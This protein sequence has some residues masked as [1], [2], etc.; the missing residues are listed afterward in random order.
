MTALAGFWRNKTPAPPP[1]DAAPA[2]M[3]VAHGITALGI[4]AI[5][6][7]L[8]LLNH[9][10]FILGPDT[11]RAVMKVTRNVYRQGFLQPLLIAL[12]LFQVGSGVCLATHS[13]VLPMD[14]FHTF[15]IASGIFLA[16]YVLG[17]TLCSCL[18]G[19]ISASKRLGLRHR[20]AV[21]VG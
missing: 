5:F 15:Q 7:A 20:R 4:I 17:H 16:A 12:F 9:L 8:H 6:L 2:P 19:S 3:R 11:Y 10:T 13:D 18:R 14:R 1:A 21:R